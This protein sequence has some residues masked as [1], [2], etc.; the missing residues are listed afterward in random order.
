MDVVTVGDGLRCTRQPDCTLLR[1]NVRI[2]KIITKKL[3]AIV[4]T[5]LRQSVLSEHYLSVLTGV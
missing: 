2:R 5:Y 1:I 3:L 4:H